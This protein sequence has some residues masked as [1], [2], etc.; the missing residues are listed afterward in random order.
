MKRLTV[1]IC[2]LAICFGAC[3]KR[4]NLKKPLE[5]LN[6]VEVAEVEK[7]AQDLYMEGKYADTVSNLKT[8]IAENPK[9]PKY[10]G[11]LG[12]AYAQLDQFT[13]SEFA[14][15][16]AIEL[17]PKNVK[18]MYN[19]SVVYS[20]H[21][22]DDEALKAVQKGLKVSPKNP[23]LQ[24]SLGNIMIDKNKLDSAQTIYERIVKAKPDFGEAHYNL[25]VIN[26]KKNNLEE[27]AKNYQAA[28]AIKPDDLEAKENLAAVYIMRQDYANATTALLEVIKANP[29]SDV[30]LENAYY[31]LGI[32]Y[33]KTDNYEGALEVFE[34]AIN[35]E[36]WDMAAY[37]N[38]AI[39]A[40]QLG[41][42][43]KAEKYWKK[44]D[45]LLPV[46]KRKAQI[47]EKLEKFE[48]AK[49]GKS[50]RETATPEQP[51][52]K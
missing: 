1:S 47:K 25:G 51:S 33:M 17:D 30:T 20:E 16:R 44:Y 32:V 28:L 52:A 37:V 8:L 5:K 46:N 14:F 27:A 48:E 15:K 50:L 7:K 35:I 9:N 11:E 13:Y 3:I 34:K 19:L 24:A 21:G 49:T 22:N 39:M 18:A 31:N 41:Q 6:V 10:W 38:A 42:Y 43:D 23:L 40:E 26:L 12:S 2:C 4:E 29:A 45:R 36:P